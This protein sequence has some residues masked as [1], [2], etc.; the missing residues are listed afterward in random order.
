MMPNLRYMG[1]S[2]VDLVETDDNGKYKGVKRLKPRQE[3]SFPDEV[4]ER[5]LRGERHMRVWVEV[6]SKEDPESNDYQPNRFD[7]VT[8]NASAEPKLDFGSTTTPR[9]AIF[10][11]DDDNE[12]GFAV[13]ASDEGPA[14][15]NA[16]LNEEEEARQA[17]EKAYADKKA[18]AAKS[19]TAKPQGG[20]Q[21][22][23]PSNTAN[24]A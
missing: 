11:T 7:A 2:G 12:E 20:A 24:K 8:G 3:I 13:A 6:G 10:R 18:A 19:S 22:Q 17:G 15:D 5:L 14:S 21:G 1:T 16:A 9:R 23:A 4:A